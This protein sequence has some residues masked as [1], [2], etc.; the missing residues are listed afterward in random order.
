MIPE[1][2]ASWDDVPSLSTPPEGPLSP[3]PVAEALGRVAPNRR[4]FLR[5]GMALGGAL[6]L[7]VLGWLPPSRLRGAG[8]VVGTEHL[9]CNVF[10]YDGI[11]CTPPVYDVRYCGR[12]GWFKSKETRIR[13]FRPVVACNNRNAWRWVDQG[14]AYRCADGEV[15]RA[16]RSPVF[17]ICNW[18]NPQPA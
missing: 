11:L 15:Q 12:D 7:S 6:A 2:H 18:P 14:T 8:A 5:G 1:V 17:K 3:S 4:S 9:D 13:V 16:P 10:S